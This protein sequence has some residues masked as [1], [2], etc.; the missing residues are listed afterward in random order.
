LPYK[1]SFEN[2]QGYTYGVE[3]VNENIDERINFHN[4]LKLGLKLDPYQCYE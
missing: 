3:I 1:A 4:M 2:M